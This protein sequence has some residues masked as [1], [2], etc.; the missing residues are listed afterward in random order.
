M[1]L[2]INSAR[3]TTQLENLEYFFLGK[4]TRLVPEK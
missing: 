1:Q 2:K 3:A 4:K